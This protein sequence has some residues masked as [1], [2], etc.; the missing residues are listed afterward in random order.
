[1]GIRFFVAVGGALAAVALA[2]ER[3]PRSVKRVAR[4]TSHADDL[5][6][7]RRLIALLLLRGELAAPEDREEAAPATPP[8]SGTDAD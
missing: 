8:P 3:C 1:M 4:A 2:A 6:A 7:R 5:A